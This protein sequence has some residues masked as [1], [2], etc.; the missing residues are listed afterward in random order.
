[1]SVV[2]DAEDGIRFG[3]R[4]GGIGALKLVGIWGGTPDADVEMV[5]HVILFPAI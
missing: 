4:F 3:G 2:A 1:M 5:I